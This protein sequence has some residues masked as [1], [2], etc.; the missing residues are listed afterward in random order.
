MDEPARM[1]RQRH[2]SQ[3]IR[4]VF[5]T[6]IV[7]ACSLRS[8]SAEPLSTKAIPPDLKPWVPWVLDGK[9]QELCPL[10]GDQPRCAWPSRLDLFLEDRSGRFSQRWHVDAPTW[11][12]LPGDMK[13]WPLDVKDSAKSIAVVTRESE[14]YV[15]LDR[16]EH[17]LTGAFAWDVMP[18]SLRI[19]KETGLLT[20]TMRGTLV[21]SPTRDAAGVVWL[22]KASTNDE[23]D[24]LEI[25]VHRKVTD[26]IPLLLTT[27]IEIHASGKNREQLLGRALPEGLVPISLES[28][29]PA[30]IEPNGH[31]R[32]QIR[33]GIFTIEIVARSE[34]IV[35][36]LARPTPNGP[37]REGYEVWVFEAK[38]AYRTVSVEGVPSI[39]PAQTTLPDAWKRL[40]A[41]PMQLTDTLTLNERRR[42]DAAPADDQLTLSR[43]LW[44][45]FDGGGL[46][47]S[48]TITGTLS[49]SSRLTIAE[50]TRLGRVSIGGVDQFITKLEGLGAGVEVR[51]NELH[52][53]ADS[54]IIANPRDLPAVSWAHDFHKVEASLKL[55]PGYRLL[56]AS[57]VDDVEGTWIRH[58]SLLE[59]FLALVLAVAISRL[60]G[61]GWGIVALVL[62]GLSFPESGVPKWIWFPVLIGE[63]LVRV[64]PSGKA[65][66]VFEWARSLALVAVAIVAV[67]FLVQHLRGGMYPA[68]AAGP[69]D[70]TLGA[71]AFQAVGGD[72]EA[73]RAI[74]NVSKAEAEPSDHPK[75]APGMGAAQ[76]SSVQAPSAALAPRDGA[77]KPDPNRRSSKDNADASGSA[78]SRTWLSQSKAKEYDPSAMVQTGPG[79]PRWQWASLD[80]HWSGPV[81]AT[82]RLHLYLLSPAQN[83]ALAIVRAVLLIIVFWRLLP[84]RG[85]FFPKGANPT[86]AAALGGLALLLGPGIARAE[87]PGSDILE[88]LQKKLVE[89]PSCNPNC[90]SSGRMRIEAHS[91][92]LRARIEVDAA[93]DASFALPGSLGQFSPRTVLID[94]QP[95]KSLARGTDGVLH[96]LLTKGHHQLIVEGAL[97]DRESL[98]LSLPQKPHRVELD[99]AGWTVEGVHEDGLADDNLQFTRKRDHASGTTLELGQ[100]PPFVRVERTIHVGLN[101]QVETRI[102]RVSPAGNAIVLEVPLLA[103]ENVTTADVRVLSGKAL[104]NMGAGTSE[105][106]W[107]SVLEQRSPIKLAAPKGVSWTEVWRLDIGPIWH[108]AYAGIPFV[109]STAAGSARTPE[110]RPWPGE[111][112][113]VELTR[114]RGI[115]GQTLTVDEAKLTVRPGLRSTDATL[116]LT[117]RSSRG[118]EHTVILPEG[119]TLESVELNAAKQPTRQEGRKVTFP[120]VPGSQSVQ[121]RWHETRALS[122]L[123]KVNAVD[124]GVPSVNATVT[125]ETPG[126]RWLLLVGGPRLGPAVLFWSLLA[127]LLIVAAMLGRY[128][129]TPVPTAHWLLL[130]VGLSQ[131][132]AV[133]GAC[134]VAW[135]LALGYRERHDG[136]ALGPLA[137]NARQ[138]GLALLT[139]TAIGLL[140]GAIYHGLL[141]EPEMQV[142]GNRSSLSWLHWFQDRSDGALPTPWMVSLPILAYRALMLGWALWTAL[143]VVRWLKWGWSAF[144]HGGGW[145]TQPKRV[146]WQNQPVPSPQGPVGPPPPPPMQG[147]STPGA[148]PLPPTPDSE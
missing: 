83:L 140:F 4:F 143:A 53:T 129:R 88:T 115:E 92:V 52:V 110:W 121:M 11:V 74:D 45:D 117:M 49:R 118:A 99:A 95:A 62:F 26:D 22:Q 113:S 17:V 36:K 40:P 116:V 133:L 50:P 8:A 100:L 63:A 90:T 82:Q 70:E 42:G 148:P 5:A 25:V 56:Y 87:I 59:L 15:Y 39:D 134:F 57:G 124:I 6:I 112:A 73:T 114:P 106:A 7:V 120:I 139:F 135:L 93:A 13:R 34:G 64:L 65:K 144:T 75:E 24:A 28:T 10:Q 125:I 136:K 27:R 81:A 2:L 33:P 146:P 84:F 3:L 102:V 127:V 107:Q 9:D 19:P 44:L 12:P 43:R 77:S 97:T 66:T 58:W 123:F 111:E 98:Q 109:Q 80:L 47:A 41:Y 60:Y 35:P 94:G 69:N 128:G 142:Q 23:G 68:L 71:Q 78:Y 14:P 29:I 96:A 105:V 108:A 30:R 104:V 38:N 21:A 20:L 91:D 72:E 137:F 46:T 138:V 126:G 55:P 48:D 130:S 76:A 18:E 67:P 89:K 79:L 51:Q 32:V 131:I 61:V 31:V 1:L 54:R 101:W 141:G 85:K 86:V 147:P 145:K 37:W 122:S 16:G 103:G 119:A 132:P